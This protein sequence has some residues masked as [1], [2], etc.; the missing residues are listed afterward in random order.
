M[1]VGIGKID[2]YLPAC[3]SLK[4]KRRVV[5]RI[6]DRAF[7]RLHVQLAEVDHLDVWQSAVLGFSLVGNDSRMIQSLIDQMFAFVAGCGEVTIVDQW[8]EIQTY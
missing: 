7:S 3:H 6:K 5:R 1:V 8:S 4:E 2:L